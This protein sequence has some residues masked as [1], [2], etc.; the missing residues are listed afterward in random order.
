V[1]GGHS[2]DDYEIQRNLK[3]IRGGEKKEEE[4]E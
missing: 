1:Q 4:E 3:L 2:K